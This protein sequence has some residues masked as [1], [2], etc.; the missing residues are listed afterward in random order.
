MG[1][2]RVLLTGGTGFIGRELLR[3][4]GARG[5]AV[6]VVSRAAGPANVASG[7]PARVSRVTWDAIE[8]EIP[9]VDAVVHLAGEPVAEGRWTA[10]RLERIRASRVET[11]T[12]IARSIE[13]AGK[14]PRVL[15]SGSAVGIYGAR[16]DDVLCD[17]G[18][19]PGTDELARIC[20]AWEA[21]ADAARASGVRVVHPRLG[22]VL[23]RDGGA[24]GKMAAP[25]KWF[26]GG[27]I[28]SGRQWTSWIHERD[29]TRALL[30]T[31]DRESL[32]GPVNVVAPEP[33]TMNDVARSIGRALGRP[34][35]VRAPAFAL[36]LALGEGLARTLLTGQRVAPRVLEREGFAFEFRSVALAID[37][38]MR[39]RSPPP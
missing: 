5:D 30:L 28:G 33:A 23:G 39:P 29:V 2:M 38:L 35:A 13:R 37:D 25:F 9:R 17:E 14:R 16:L 1:S 15:V 22:V 20:V 8:A 36:R 4:L 19:P 6:V 31:I 27:P 32:S 18:S 21:A 26:V 34:D 11:T 12:R 7:D 24:L 10:E 3:A